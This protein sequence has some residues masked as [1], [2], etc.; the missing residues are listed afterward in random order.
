MG[1]LEA[2]TLSTLQPDAASDAATNSAKTSGLRSLQVGILA[3][4][5]LAEAFDEGLGTQFEAAVQL[6]LRTTGRLVVAGVGKSGHIGR[7]IAAT[8]ASTGTPAL[9]VHPTEASHGDL[10]MITPNDTL[11]AL[12]WSGETVELGDLIGYSRRFRVPLIAMTGN[13]ASTLGRAADVVLALPKVRE[14]CPHD[15]APTSSTQIQLALGDALAVALLELRGFTASSFKIFHPG[16]KLAARLMSV[17]QLM[18]TGEEMP[19]VQRGTKMSDALLAIAGRRFGCAGILD[20]D[21]R[22][23]GIITDGDLRRHMCA[24]FLDM[25]VDD[26][27]TRDPVTVEPDLLASAALELMNSRRITSLFVV[28]HAVPVGVVHVHDLLRAGVI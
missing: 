13:E 10:G 23:A 2:V 4:R 9:F 11:L 8:L 24:G 21:G 19:L 25:N 15:L 16:G 22:L 20:E 5:R 3:M 17:R 7:K 18:H 6:I 27:M 1:T 14:S 26:V 12:S 28:S